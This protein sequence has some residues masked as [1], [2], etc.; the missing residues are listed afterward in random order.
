M[1]ERGDVQL[2]NMLGR[3]PIIE[4]LEVLGQDIRLHEHLVILIREARNLLG[5]AYS[6]RGKGEILVAIRRL[7]EDRIRYRIELSPQNGDSCDRQVMFLAKKKKAC[8]LATVALRLVFP[9]SVLLSHWKGE[10][11]VLMWDPLETFEECLLIL[12]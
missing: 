9:S 6:K 12:E 5:A 11:D 3:S 2:V 7:D 10:I 1:L 8:V 4:T